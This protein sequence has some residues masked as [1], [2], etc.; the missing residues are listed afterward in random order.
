MRRDMGGANGSLVDPYIFAAIPVGS[1]NAMTALDIWRR[2]G[3]WSPNTI[4]QRLKTLSDQGG[5][6]RRRSEFTTHNERHLFWFEPVAHERV[7][8]G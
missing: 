3:C 4:R 7:E 1:E 2:M 8:I 6:F 5:P